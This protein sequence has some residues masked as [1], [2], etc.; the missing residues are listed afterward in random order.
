MKIQ[1][2][3]VFMG[4]LFLSSLSTAQT[5][6]DIY[7]AYV[8]NN[9]EDIYVRQKPDILI[10]H[11]DVATPIALPPEVE[12]ILDQGI[13]G[14][15]TV[16]SPDSG[17]NINNWSSSAIE[18]ILSDFNVDGVL[19]FLL[20]G[21]ESAISG[22][23]DQLLFSST[24]GQIPTAITPIDQ[25]FKSFVTNVYGTVLDDGYMDQFVET[26]TVYND[27][28]FCEFS[29]VDPYAP[30]GPLDGNNGEDVPI[31]HNEGYFEF[32]WSDWYGE[33]YCWEVTTQH[34]VSV[35]NDSA[36][37][38]AIDLLSKIWQIEY[39]YAVID[40][41]ED[42][43][44]GVF[45]T[46]FGSDVGDV[47]VIDD[48]Y[49]QNE[50]DRDEAISLSLIRVLDS[51]AE[52]PTTPKVQVRARK[53]LPF[54]L[55]SGLLGRKYAHLS[56]HHPDVEN[57]PPPF[58]QDT[59]TEYWYSAFPSQGAGVLWEDGGTLDK[60][61]TPRSSDGPLPWGG[62]MLV[63]YVNT[64]YPYTDAYEFWDVIS[65]RFDH[66]QNGQLTYCLFPEEDESAFGYECF[67]YN[68]N[69]F[70]M[71]LVQSTTLFQSI[72]V[73]LGGYSVGSELS[74]TSVYPGASEP[75]PYEY[76]Q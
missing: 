15:F 68:S 4:A 63:G 39:G 10:L 41:I 53:V 1:G 49:S 31:I 19:D 46:V 3:L 25:G 30:G 61:L 26:T 28:Y 60:A 54:F 50:Y 27:Y 5:Y 9:G 20:K 52:P 37:A 56:L 17:F 57:T 67:G 16:S 45:G 38:R 43:V 62:S 40:D 64:P 24:P 55:R 71:G 18:V 36:D 76:F 69:S 48:T 21:I 66:Y 34:E 44:E 42:I 35:Y 65:D 14:E 11:G 8:S 32:D 51:Y 74:D 2:I 73:Q 22:S 13:D 75:V 58:F 70:V 29:P 6:G 33:E 7:E 72:F 12:F 47:P 59:S 23:F